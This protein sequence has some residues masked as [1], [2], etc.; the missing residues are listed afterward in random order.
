L[1]A[2]VLGVMIVAVNGLDHW[3]Y[4]GGFL[5]AALATA[6]VIVSV[7]HPESPVRRLL[8][9]RPLVWI[10]RI[11]YGL[12]LW[13]WLIYVA[14]TPGRTG[15]SGW[16]LLFLRLAT[17][18]V[19]AAL[20]FRLVEMPVRTW[21]PKRPSW[22]QLP[23]VATGAVAV[24]AGLLVASTVGA[25]P[26]LPTAGGVPGPEPSGSGPAL[27]RRPPPPVRAV[28]SPDRLRILVVGDSVGF[29]LG[30]HYKA[31]MVKGATVKTAALIG[32]GVVRGQHVINGRLSIPNKN[33]ETWP[34]R[35]TQA[36]DSFDPDIT[37]IMVGAW[38]VYDR[39]VDGRMLRVGTPEYERYL[40]SEME[41]AL[42]IVAERGAPIALMNVPCY[43]Q[44]NLQLGDPPSE[45]NDPARVAWL[46]QVF[47][48]IVARH[49]KRLH[50]IDVGSFLCPGG[51]DAQKMNGVQVRRDGVHFTPEGAGLVWRWMGPQLVDLATHPNG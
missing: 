1:G 35:W 48:R 16:P 38:E 11:S 30:Y 29:S 2:G 24:V 37:V 22:W 3:L 41:L 31:G 34:A 46:N 39:K 6:A 32:C 40:D 12:Y 20:S 45:R 14:L 15:V 51:H 19:V 43:D 33:C 36:V 23:A 21:R 9:P 4:Q 28:P 27:V 42:G 26:A 18:G 47:Q 17:T 25:P 49:T 50:L 13:H 10:G 5:I 8:S 7:V 44:P